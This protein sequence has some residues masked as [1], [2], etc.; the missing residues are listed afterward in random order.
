MNLRPLFLASGLTGLLCG[1]V[2]AQSRNESEPIP[3]AQAPMRASP[4][5]PGAENQKL[6]RQPAAMVLLVDPTTAHGIV[7]KFRAAYGSDSSPRI[8]VYVNRALIDTGAGLRLTGHTEKYERAADN[9][10]R[11]SGENTYQFREAP[12]PTLADQQT[13]RDIERLFGRVF[14]NANARLA[15]Q[16]TAVD[17]L[18]DKP[19]ERLVGDQAAREREALTSVADIA[20]EVLISSRNLTLPGVSGDQ[21]VAVPDIQ[22]TAIRLKDAAI[23]GQASASDVLGKDA[24]AGR[25]AQSFDVRDITEATALAL[26][27]DMLTGAPAPVK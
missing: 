4:I 10:V 27:D 6:Y 23:L 22:A 21:V 2:L 5:M 3:V 26:M 16:Q 13:V 14:R 19:G 17:L 8:V 24:Q 20:I 9:A 11:T 25:A 15:D 18:A 12:K 7:D 1:P